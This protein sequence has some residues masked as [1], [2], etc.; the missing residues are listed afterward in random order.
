MILRALGCSGSVLPGE[1]HFSLLVGSSVLID[2]GS[3]ASALTLEEQCAVRDILL[4]HAHLDHTKDIGF[5]AENVFLRI[6]EPVR[7][8]GTRE[9][10]ESVRRHLLNDSVWPD[11]TSLPT[12]ADPTLIYT[13]F[14]PDETLTLGDLTVH[15]MPNGHMPGSVGFLLSS[16]VGAVFVSG[17]TGPTD[18]VPLPML[19]SRDRIRAVLMEVSFPNRLQDVATA[20]RHLT[21]ATLAGQ[22]ERMAL[23]D[24]PVYLFH[25]KG[26]ARD[27]TIR[28]IDALGDDRFRLLRPGT[29]IVF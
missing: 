22:I 6:E 1:S 25:L 24:V 8:H 10:L 23:P 3:A 19:R 18:Q 13:P 7:L 21:P 20:S 14:G 28:E 5:F 17:D 27:E 16:P 26:S 9:T 12:D 29:E 4:T 2:M 15:P 11:F